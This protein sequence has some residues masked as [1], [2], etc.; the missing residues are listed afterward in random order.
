MTTVKRD[1]KELA[2]AILKD[3]EAKEETQQKLTPFVEAG[4]LWTG[5]KARKP[6]ACGMVY[7][8]YNNGEFQIHF[9]GQA[10]ERFDTA[11]DALKLVAEVEE[12][13]KR[14]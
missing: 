1:P 6:I 14:Y 3:C 13:L 11:E 9:P 5:V 4:W 2:A 10:N 12:Q 7:A 8:T